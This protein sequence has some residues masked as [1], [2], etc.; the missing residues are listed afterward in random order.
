MNQADK[1]YD[2]VMEE[3]KERL[4]RMAPWNM[5]AKQAE[6]VDNTKKILGG[7]PMK[8]KAI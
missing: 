6:M 5:I 4:E 7:I 3:L 8:M 2:A 1:E